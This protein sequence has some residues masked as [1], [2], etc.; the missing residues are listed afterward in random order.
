MPSSTLGVPTSGMSFSHFGPLSVRWYGLMYLAGFAL[1]VVLQLAYLF[2]GLD[3]LE[4][5]G[6]RHLNAAPGFG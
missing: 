3:T 6:R 2:G 5:T 4:A 1:F